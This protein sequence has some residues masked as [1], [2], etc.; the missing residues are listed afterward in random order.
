MIKKISLFF[1]ISLFYILPGYAAQCDPFTISCRNTNELLT[2]Y[3]VTA[4]SMVGIIDKK[5]Q[6]WAIIK[7][8][9]QHVYSVTTGSPIGLGGGKVIRITSRQ[10]I[11]QQ[12]KKSV[13]IWLQQVK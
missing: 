10:I 9:D 5:N 11:V 6:I 8:P 1:G 12:E 13:T 4:L 3:P 7:A 2:K